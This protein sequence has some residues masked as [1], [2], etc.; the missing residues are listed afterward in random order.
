MWTPRWWYKMGRR[1]RCIEWV[2]PLHMITL[3]HFMWIWSKKRSFFPFC[4]RGSGSEVGKSFCLKFPIE[5]VEI[6]PRKYL[7]QAMEQDC[8]N[9]IST[10]R[11]QDG[12][13]TLLT[14]LWN[15]ITLSLVLVY[16]FSPPRP[17]WLVSWIKSLGSGSQGT[18]RP[19]KR[20]RGVQQFA[21]QRFF[22]AYGNV[23]YLWGHGDWWWSKTVALCV[24]LALSCSCRGWNTL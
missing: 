8:L 15:L 20:E 11:F 7:T 14:T 1:N 18:W 4:R 3:A 22:S 2:F 19:G 17:A 5:L 23:E 13:A 10:F 21:S 12:M 9:S 24:A 6:T 16:A